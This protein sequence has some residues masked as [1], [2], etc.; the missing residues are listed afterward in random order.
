ME[1]LKSELASLKEAK[2]EEKKRQIQLEQ[3][4]TTLTEE[5]KKERV[6][7]TFLSYMAHSF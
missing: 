6:T 3:E 5:L 1:E 4:H 2:R 7:Q